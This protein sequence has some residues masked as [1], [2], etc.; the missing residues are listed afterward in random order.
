[1]KNEIKLSA[2]MFVQYIMLPVWFV[3]MLPYV[4]SLPPPHGPCGAAS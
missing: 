2:M 3:P 1:M 4:E